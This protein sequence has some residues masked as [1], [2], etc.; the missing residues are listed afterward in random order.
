MR[1]G[2]NTIIVSGLNS[3]IF[4]STAGSSDQ[5]SGLHQIITDYSCSFSSGYWHIQQHS[6]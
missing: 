4:N 3:A 1:L 6:V 5:Q 2:M